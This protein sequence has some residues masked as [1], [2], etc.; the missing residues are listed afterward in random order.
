MKWLSTITEA[1]EGQIRIEKMLLDENGQ[2]Q[3]TGEFETIDADSV[4]LA[5]GQET[6]LSF[7]DKVD[8]LVINRGNVEVSMSMMTGHPG[9]FAGGD[10]IPGDRNVT[11]AIGHGKRA[12]R[13]IDAWLRGEVLAEESPAELATFSRLNTWYY[14]DAPKTVRPQLDLVRR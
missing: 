8:G 10:M 11:V 5:L 6:N 7:L 12:A 9:I 4:V 14:A 3:P 2:P 1:E 13:H